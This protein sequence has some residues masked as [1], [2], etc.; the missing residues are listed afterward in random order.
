MT[1]DQRPGYFITGF[2][3]SPRVYRNTTA[4]DLPGSRFLTESVR[5]VYGVPNLSFESFGVPDPIERAYEILKRA[6][7]LQSVYITRYHPQAHVN[8]ERNKNPLEVAT[9]PVIE[10]I[11][12]ELIWEHS[13]RETEYERTNARVFR[14]AMLNLGLKWSDGY[15]G[16]VPKNEVEAFLGANDDLYLKVK[17]H[18]KPPA[19]SRVRVEGLDDLFDSININESSG[20]VLDPLTS[21][22]LR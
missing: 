20:E 7:N 17:P 3:A 14:E 2:M 12:D 15:K 10:R 19:Y 16:K 13:A 6:Q 9:N 5:I 1:C 22:P 21:L 4:P 18:I 8:W 11:F